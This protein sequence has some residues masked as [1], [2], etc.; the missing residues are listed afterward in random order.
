MATPQPNTLQK[1]MLEDIRADLQKQK[2]KLDEWCEQVHWC[3][4]AMTQLKETDAPGIKA[5]SNTF[6]QLGTTFNAIVEAL[7]DLALQSNAAVSTSPP[8][9]EP[10]RATAPAIPRPVPHHGASYP[11]VAVGV[12]PPASLPCRVKTPPRMTP[13]ASKAPLSGPTST[14]N[15]PLPSPHASV[16]GF[17]MT[18]KAEDHAA[19]MRAWSN[20]PSESNSRP[21]STVEEWT[22]GDSQPTTR[23]TSPLLQGDLRSHSAPPTAMA[24]TAAQ[25]H[26][27][28]RLPSEVGFG[29]RK[30]SSVSEEVNEAD[31]SAATQSA[32]RREKKTR[33]EDLH[34][35]Q[36]DAKVS[37][38]TQSDAQQAALPPPSYDEAQQ[39]L[40]K[41]RLSSE[42]GS[43]KRK[44]SSVSE[45]VHHASAATE[46]GPNVNG[47]WASGAPLQLGISKD[48]VVD[49]RPNQSLRPG[50]LTIRKSV[51]RVAQ[52]EFPELPRADS[53][54]AE[55]NDLRNPVGEVRPLSVIP[56][57]HP[58]KTKAKPAAAV[59]G[60]KP[61]SPVSVVAPPHINE[62]LI[63][64]FN[65]LEGHQ[66]PTAHGV[67]EGG[68]TFPRVPISLP[69][70]HRK[71]K[72]A[73]IQHLEKQL[74]TKCSWSD[75]FGR[76]LPIK[77]FSD[78][79]D[80]ERENIMGI[81]LLRCKVEKRP[82]DFVLMSIED[83]GA[84]LNDHRQIVWSPTQ[85]SY[86]FLGTPASGLNTSHKRAYEAMDR[87]RR[88]Y[89]MLSR[90]D[91]WNAEGLTARINKRYDAVLVSWMRHAF[92][93]A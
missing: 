3:S 93:D 34:R 65:V 23:G 66:H 85:R 18:A 67:P 38:G 14:S 35:Q 72:A 73:A 43:G 22:P 5:C 54:D 58:P 26:V 16:Y 90:N 80:P 78:L 76:Y 13:P 2:T 82:S 48:S 61:F 89:D 8:T 42:V 88:L 39:G 55:T 84:Y 92:F 7:D 25:Q 83:N 71:D 51:A 28:H 44:S 63:W 69:L 15:T 12:A 53:P 10:P 29:E 74:V 87:L 81:S 52:M 21:A 17:T 59:V 37:S 36:E 24:A 75:H 86:C 19:V 33:K 60:L 68:R 62:D 30:P 40:R 57:N 9:T 77:R 64:F 31:A 47:A 6:R 27:S 1:L 50:S 11:T 4:N 45:E 91:Q 79:A 70:N 32:E 20:P 56:A 49:R 41:L 46:L